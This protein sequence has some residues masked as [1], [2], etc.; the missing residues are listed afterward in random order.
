MLKQCTLPQLYYAPVPT[1]NPATQ[2]NNEI[3]MIPFLLVHE[4]LAS[5]VK[6]SQRTLREYCDC[7]PSVE[8]L[9]ADFCTKT[10][11]PRTGVVPIGFHGDGVPHQK[12]RSVQV[13]SWNL[14]AK[15]SAERLLFAVIGKEFC[16]KCGCKGRHTT[17]AILSV[18]SWSMK[19]LLQGFWPSCRHDGSAWSDSDKSRAQLQGEMGVRAMLCQS[20]G[21]WAWV[22]EVFGFPAWSSSEICW[23]CEANR[24]DVPFSDFSLSAA[25]R[26]KRRSATS[27]FA[28]L[29]EQGIPRS[30][31]FGCPGFHV[32][33]VVIDLLHACDLGVSQVALGNLFYELLPTVG[34]VRA[35]Q[36]ANLWAKIKTYYRNGNAPSQIQTLTLEMIRLPN[37]GPKLRTKGAETRGLVPFGAQLAREHNANEG[38]S[39]S[40][41]LMRTF[42]YLLEFYMFVSQEPY[43]APE[44]AIAARNFLLLYKSLGA[45]AGGGSDP[46][47]WIVKPKFHM[48]QELAEF[49]APDLDASPATFWA[50]KDEDFVG[51]VAQFAGSRGGANHCQ[52]SCVRTMQRYRAWVREL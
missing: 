17:D 14:L 22:K 47:L 52:N 41:A 2:T 28:R 31:L 37:K 38:S 24:D 13:F 9:V 36:V 18:F 15:P 19:L 10:N 3:V 21:D 44:A 6:N 4:V 50:Y 43:N 39:R 34:S 5:M 40:H 7:S 48:M 16:C 11:V 30:P 26:K 12:N 20:R 27:L 42:K 25:W 49:Q 51:F 32:S 45:H 8:R 46:K 29:R 1:H 33:M 23:L 35:E